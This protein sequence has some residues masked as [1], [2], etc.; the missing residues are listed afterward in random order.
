MRRLGLIVVVGGLAAFLA[1]AAAG[2]EPRAGPPDGGRQPY[3]ALRKKADGLRDEMNELRRVYDDDPEVSAVAKAS[4]T[5]QKAWDE[6]MKTSP[7]IGRAREGMTAARKRLDEA[8]AAAMAAD[9]QAAPVARRYQ[10][11]TKRLEAIKVEQQMLMEEE[12]KL[13][14]D[15][16]EHRQRVYRN[17]ETAREAR[18]AMEAAQ[19]AYSEVVRGDAAVQEARKAH[20]EAREK[21]HKVRDAKLA[22]DPLYAE[23]AEKYK[24][25]D[26]QMR[27]A[28]EGTKQKK[29]ERE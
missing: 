1:T 11:V 10:E 24:A 9:P 3:D 21:H 26:A 13:R 19:R 23:L 27:A 12:R 2:E 14:R 22:A 15:F 7:A 4:A 6:A 16:D 28:R 18:A 8:V 5:A 29:R 20:E 17:P 25:V